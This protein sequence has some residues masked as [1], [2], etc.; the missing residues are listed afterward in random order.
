MAL[1]TTNVSE[2]L[3]ASIIR[4]TS[5]FV[6]LRSMRRLLV[7][8]N[9]VPSSPILVTLMMEALRSCETSVLTRATRRHNSGEDISFW[10]VVNKQMSIGAC[11]L[12]SRCKWVFTCRVLPQLS[13]FSVSSQSWRMR[14]EEWFCTDTPARALVLPLRISVH[15]WVL[16]T[17]HK[18][19]QHFLKPH[20]ARM[21]V[22]PDIVYA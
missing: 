22:W 4:V 19:F 8:A 9:D 16:S 12:L 11:Q 5:D 2:E 3:R 21:C 6:F 14:C 1:V 7:R 15:L 20:G 13:L 17:F 18:I 10:S